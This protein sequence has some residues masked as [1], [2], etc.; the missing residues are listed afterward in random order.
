MTFAEIEHPIE[1]QKSVALA[2][3]TRIEP[4]RPKVYWWSRME[5]SPML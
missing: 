2:E 5:V 3:P 4:V 1:R